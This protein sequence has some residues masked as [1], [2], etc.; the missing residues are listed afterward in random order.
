MHF[1]SVIIPIYNT[2]KFLMRCLNSVLSQDFTDYEIICID[3]CS[4]GNCQEII[5]TI[6]SNKIKYFRNDKNLGTHMSR[7]RGVEIADSKYSL[8]LDSD[9]FYKKNTFLYLFK[10]LNSMNIDQL[11]FG[12]FSIP[13]KNKSIFQYDKNKDSI[14]EKVIRGEKSYTNFSLCNK[15]TKTSIL[16]TAF[17]RMDKFY[18]IWFEDGYEQ[19]FISSICKKFD[20]LKKYLLVLDETSGITTTSS[21]ISA[22]KFLIRCENID[23]VLTSL[24]NYIINYDLDKYLPV[25]KN[26]EDIHPSYL[27]QTFL[28][29]IKENELITAINGLFDFFP[30]KLIEHNLYLLIHKQHV[31]FFKKLKIKFLRLVK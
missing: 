3:D 18:C 16:K 11:E 4:P 12:Y 1:F 28:P 14:L 8:F 21:E 24:R 27:I 23:K 6:N 2:E 15:I 30:S 31:S 10:K 25:I 9:D 13:N 22:S 7:M 26:S 5:E 29:T 20:S 17:S 19:F